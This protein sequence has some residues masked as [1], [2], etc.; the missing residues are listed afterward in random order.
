MSYIACNCRSLIADAKLRRAAIISADFVRASQ[1][2][3]N[4]TA[5]AALRTFIAFLSLRRRRN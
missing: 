5:S 3:V 4:R 2:P 1:I